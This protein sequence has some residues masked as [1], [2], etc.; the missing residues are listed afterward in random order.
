M[1]CAV[2]AGVTVFAGLA[3]KLTIDG[4]KADGVLVVPTT[5]VEG[6]VGTGS[7]YV[8]GADGAKPAKQAVGL[9]LT[10]GVHVQI[11]E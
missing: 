9:G 2:P 8:A 11:T 10:D 1:K 6:S 4:G 5:A 3:A 7:V